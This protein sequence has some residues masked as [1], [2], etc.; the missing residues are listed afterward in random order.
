MK[1]RLHRSLYFQ[2]VIALVAGIA[3]GHFYPKLAP[4][5]SPSG[6]RS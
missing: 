4:I 6:P 5:S 1:K 3:V 2:V